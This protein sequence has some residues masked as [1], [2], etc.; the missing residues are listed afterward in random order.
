MSADVPRSPDSS[1]DAAEDRSIGC[2][3]CG[4]RVLPELLA[5]HVEETHK[6]AELLKSLVS[7][8]DPHV[9][10]VPPLVPHSNLK[11]KTVPRRASTDTPTKPAAPRKA[12]APRGAAG[13]KAPKVPE[14]EVHMQVPAVDSPPFLTKADFER[15][16][17][18]KDKRPA[19]PPSGGDAQ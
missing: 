2:P 8:P 15:E 13:T 5:D 11:G 14:R 1:G 10:T 7:F 19:A 4:E 9:Q 16:R 12:R 17:A 3:Y 6:R 18:A